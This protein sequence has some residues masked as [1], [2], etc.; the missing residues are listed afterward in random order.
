MA[1]RV[2]FIGGDMD[3]M[4]SLVEQHKIKDKTDHNKLWGK[5]SIIVDERLESELTD[6]Q[7]ADEYT[8]GYSEKLAGKEGIE[9]TKD[10]EQ[11]YRKTFLVH[12]SEMQGENAKGD[13]LIQH[14]PFDQE[15]GTTQLA[16]EAKEEFTKAEK[17]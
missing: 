17:K 6:E 8:D 9:L 4:K 10:G 13:R 3:L 16:Q 5:H 7:K 11:I 2:A 12:E 1:T 14:D 15:T